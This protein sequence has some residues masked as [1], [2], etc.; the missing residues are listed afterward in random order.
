MIKREVQAFYPIPDDRFSI[1]HPG[2]DLPD[3]GDAALGLFVG[4][5]LALWGLRRAWRPQA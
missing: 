5:M 4:M 3:A 1:A 2:A